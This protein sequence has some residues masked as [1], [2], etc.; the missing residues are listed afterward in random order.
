MDEPGLTALLLAVVL[1]TVPFSGLFPGLSVGV[2]FL[3][4]RLEAYGSA[5]AGLASSGRRGRR[6][7]ADI[8]DPEAAAA[9]VVGFRPEVDVVD[10]A[11]GGREFLIVDDL[12]GE[13]VDCAEL[14]REGMFLE[15]ASCAARL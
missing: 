12:T 9:V 3:A 7:G 4:A 5:V 14:G 11:E 2:T 15:A 13:K 10:S 8:K 6:T 1:F